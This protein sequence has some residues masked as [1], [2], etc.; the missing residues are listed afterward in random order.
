MLK[1][2]FRELKRSAI[3]ELIQAAADSEQVLVQAYNIS[4]H[5]N[6]QLACFLSDG[7]H[8]IKAF[9]KNKSIIQPSIIFLI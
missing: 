9:F 1:E 6:D 2:E 7:N 5:K 4:V 3:T 8:C